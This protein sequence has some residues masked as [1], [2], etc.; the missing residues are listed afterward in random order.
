MPR[1][2]ALIGLT[3]LHAAIPEATPSPWR[4]DWAEAAERYGQAPLPEA[5]VDPVGLV[6][7]DHAAVI[8]LA[9]QVADMAVETALAA[10]RRGG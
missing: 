8:E 10:M 2:W 6:E 9:R 1:S 7:P 5:F 4:F 3:Q